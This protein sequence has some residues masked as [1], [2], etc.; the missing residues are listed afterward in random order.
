MFP[1]HQQNIWESKHKA[2]EAEWE[3]QPE[4][5]AGGTAQAERMLRAWSHV[6]SVHP[7]CMGQLC[8]LLGEHLCRME[9]SQVTA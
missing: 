1:L 4:G 5:Q 6:P 9:P 2:G 8:W 7:G 3:S